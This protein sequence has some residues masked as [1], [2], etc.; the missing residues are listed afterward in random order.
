MRVL[1][2]TNVLLAAF[3]FAGADVLVTGD[4]DLLALGEFRGCRILSPREF[5]QR[6]K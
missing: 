3:G 1:A 2:D 5:W 4:K 6:L